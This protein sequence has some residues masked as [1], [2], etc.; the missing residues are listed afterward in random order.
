MASKDLRAPGDVLV[1]LRRARD[2][3]DRH[4]AGPL[5]L[6]EL[7]GLLAPGGRETLLARYADLARLATFAAPQLKITAEGSISG[8]P[9]RATI[10]IIVVPLPE[11][12]AVIRRQM[13]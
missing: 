6:D 4:Y 13:W 9:P 1:H 12:L 11:R 7:A 5:S 2:H 10:T 8:E 3:A